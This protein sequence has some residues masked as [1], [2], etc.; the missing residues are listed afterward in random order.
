MAIRDSCWRLAVPAAGS[1]VVAAGCSV[2]VR[3]AAIVI[4]VVREAVHSWSIVVAVIAIVKGLT[5]IAS[6]KTTRA[7]SVK[8][9]RK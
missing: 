6:A 8:G 9:K 2:K 5:I 4:V 1:I 3:V 7:I